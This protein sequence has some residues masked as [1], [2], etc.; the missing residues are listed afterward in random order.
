MAYKWGSAGKQL[1]RS[2][3]KATRLR[4]TYCLAMSWG[5]DEL[6]DALAASKS[7]VV[8]ITCSLS[9]REAKNA[10]HGSVGEETYIDLNSPAELEYCTISF[11]DHRDP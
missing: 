10:G 7:D 3:L 1:I 5:M 6:V 4:P 11:T 9:R 2:S 8:D